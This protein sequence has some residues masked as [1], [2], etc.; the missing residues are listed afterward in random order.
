MYKAFNYSPGN[1]FYNTHLNRFL[2]SGSELYEAHK[3]EVQNCLSEYISDDGI[4]NGT[5]LRE[6]WF[7]VNRTDVFISHSHADLNKV[8][9]FAGWLY[10]KFG[11]TSFIDSCSWGYCDDLLKKID[12]KYCY[13]KK[14]DTYDY[15]LRNYTTSHVHMML[16]TALTEMI[17]QSECVIFFNSPN[18]IV[19]KDELEKVN[20][21]QKTTSPWILYELTMVSEM[22]CILPK[23]KKT[24]LEHFAKDEHR[25]FT[26]EY[27]VTKQIKQLFSLTD[28]DLKAL[29]S[30]HKPNIHPL[31]ELYE[32]VQKRRSIL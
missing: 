9:A 4:I 8:K 3:K 7:S 14:T 16:A 24:V 31:D 10:T 26:I 23:R 22:R 15:N 13:N 12:K 29:D 28:E 30:Q 5:E 20:K 25:D 19:M 21:K 17:E 32:I 6:H 1:P 18:S 27:D 11:L 2:Q